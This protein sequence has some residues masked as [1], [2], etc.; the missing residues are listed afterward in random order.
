MIELLDLITYIK[1][2][3]IN[4]DPPNSLGSGGSTC[5]GFLSGESSSEVLFHDPS[6]GHQFSASLNAAAPLVHG[7]LPDILL[8]HFDGDIY[9]WYIYSMTGFIR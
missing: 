2:I 4:Y 8:S 5:G 9:K 7:Q 6:Q 3:T 1:A